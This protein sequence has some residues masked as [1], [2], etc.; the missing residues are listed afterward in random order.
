MASFFSNFSSTLSDVSNLSGSVSTLSVNL[1]TTTSDLTNLSGLVNSNTVNLSNLSGTVNN[2]SVDLSNLSGAHTSLS[3]NFN[4]LSSNVSNLS[5]TV[6]TNSVDIS[7]LSGSVS[8]NT[9]NLTTVSGVLSP[10]SLGATLTSNLSSTNW[11]YERYVRYDVTVPSGSNTYH[12]NSVP[13]SEVTFNV[14]YDNTYYF[15]TTQLS[16]VTFVLSS[17]PYVENELPSGYVS[18]NYSYTV[19]KVP[20]TYCKPVYVLNSNDVN[21]GGADY[22]KPYL[23]Y[24]NYATVSGNRNVRNRDSLLCYGDTTL[25]LP[26]GAEGYKFTFNVLSGTTSYY[27]SGSDVFFDGSTSGTLSNSGAVAF[28]TNNTWF[29]R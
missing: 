12:F 26:L 17:T 10:T 23:N 11:S 1:S 5:G 6:A 19:L 27:C 22:D 29:L 7:T 25:Y 9:L 16:G 28:Y 15:D 8:N 14:E 4:N 2:L 3:V 18:K 20:R 21:F 24:G 13:L